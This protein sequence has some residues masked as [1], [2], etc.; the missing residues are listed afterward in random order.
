MKIIYAESLIEIMMSSC[1]CESRFV[2][3]GFLSIQ[4]FKVYYM[5]FKKVREALN[6]LVF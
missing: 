4:L 2:L 5:D 1:E 3:V 6:S